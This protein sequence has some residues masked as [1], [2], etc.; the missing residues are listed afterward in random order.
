V[1]RHINPLEKVE[2]GEHETIEEFTARLHDLYAWERTKK[3]AAQF[4]AFEKYGHLPDDEE[5]FEDG[6]LGPTVIY[7]WD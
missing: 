2:Q 6:T 4:P 3:Y 7:F 1:K 5:V